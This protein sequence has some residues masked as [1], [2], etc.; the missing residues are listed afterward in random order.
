[1]TEN[2]FWFK[3]VDFRQGITLN[4][5]SASRGLGIPI[6]RFSRFLNEI[7]YLNAESG[8]QLF[9]NSGYFSYL[10]CDRRHPTLEQ[11]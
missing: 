5:N 9:Q 4:I 3:G 2:G 11:P 10:Q 7:L 6:C 8:F 1:M